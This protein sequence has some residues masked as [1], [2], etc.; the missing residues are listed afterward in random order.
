MAMINLIDLAA[1]TSAATTPP[2]HAEGS[3]SREDDLPA[4]MTPAIG[5]ARRLAGLD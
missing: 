5:H 4:P 1:A 3:I 2:R